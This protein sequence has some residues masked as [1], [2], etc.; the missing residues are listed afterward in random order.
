MLLSEAGECAV[1]TNPDGAGG[2]R[3]IYY[4]KKLWP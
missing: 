2:F 4:P 1:D 3:D